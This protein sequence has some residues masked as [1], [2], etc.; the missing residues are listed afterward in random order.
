MCELNSIV[1]HSVPEWFRLAYGNVLSQFF[2]S[3]CLTNA[4][5]GLSEVVAV[6]L[7]YL[8]LWEKNIQLVRQLCI[9]VSENEKEADNPA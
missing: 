5:L 6:Y 8:D 4:D 2:S 1:I 3:P 9:F 7:V